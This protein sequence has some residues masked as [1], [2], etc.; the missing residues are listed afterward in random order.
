MRRL[1]QEWVWPPR[2]AVLFAAAWIAISWMGASSSCAR[3]DTAPERRGERHALLVGVTRYPQLG[4]AFQLRGPSRDVALM[5]RVAVE[6]LGI[7]ADHIESLTEDEGA[8]DPAR[9]PSFANI[10]AAWKRLT[11]RARAGDQVLVFLAGHGSQQPQSVDATAPEL[12]GQDELFLPRDAAPWDAVKGRIPQA[13]RD[14]D[15][16]G[17]LKQLGDQGVSV[18]LIVDSCHSGTMMRGPKETVRQVPPEALGIPPAAREAAR[19]R[20]TQRRGAV[21]RGAALKESAF[22]LATS[23]GIAALYACQPGE[24]TVEQNLPLEASDAGP[25]G[26]LTY[27]LCQELTRA[28]QSST[29]PLTYRELLGR[30]RK[31]YAAIP[32]DIPSPLGEGSDLDREILGDKVWPGRSSIRLIESDH[33][34]AGAVQ[35]VTEESILAVFPE[36]GAAGPPLG[37]VR[38]VNVEAFRAEVV[39]CEFAGQPAREDLPAGAIGRLVYV[40]HGDK[41]FRIAVEE[42]AHGGAPWGKALRDEWQERIKSIVGR[43]PRLAYAPSVADADLIVRV[44]RQ[45]LTLVPATQWEGQTGGSANPALGPFSTD[46][47]FEGDLALRLEAVAR[48]TGLVQMAAQASDDLAN[49][50]ARPRLEIEILLR[51]KETRDASPRSVLW[52]EGDTIF[53]DGDQVTLKFANAGDTPLDLHVLYVDSQ[54]GI[55][56]LFPADSDPTN[57]IDAGRSLSIDDLRIDASTVGQEHLV[58]IALRGEGETLDLSALAQ[59]RLAPLPIVPAARRSAIT[60]GLQSPLGRLLSHRM[61]GQGIKRGVSQQ[62]IENYRMQVITWRVQGS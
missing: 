17:W 7:P 11:Q 57:R 61:N 1:T 19:T 50:G 33:I 37:H 21:T 35:G 45:Q 51:S 2:I 14:D 54:F 60:R 25:H 5:R 46:Q 10:E 41:P 58:V 36:E 22:Q 20:G 23:P 26:L 59:P 28:A 32:R 9:L 13:I 6:T 34:N 38:V 39:P 31:N 44:G 27:I 47:P 48:A 30:I 40:D 43:V 12:D 15:L 3:E 53:K 4:A 62:D 18:W 55:T 56:S 16:A 52:S 29:K 42:Q 8:S 24:V 49:V